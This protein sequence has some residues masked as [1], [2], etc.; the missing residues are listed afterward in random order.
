MANFSEEG[1][2]IT[3]RWMS[4]LKMERELL[5]DTEIS[6]LSGLEVELWIILDPM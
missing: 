5:S 3:T 1:Q 6:N 2:K 4:H